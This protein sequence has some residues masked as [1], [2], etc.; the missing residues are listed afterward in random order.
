MNQNL[1]AGLAFIV[2]GLYLSATGFLP[3]VAAAVL[4]SVSSLVILFNSARLVRSG[5]ELESVPA[6]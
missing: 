4:H 2:G 1:L 5:E 3:P 6:S